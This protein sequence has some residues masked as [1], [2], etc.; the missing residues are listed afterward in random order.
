MA[1]AI[2]LDD[3]AAQWIR[4]VGRLSDGATPEQALSDLN[5][6]GV[7]T[8]ILDVGLRPFLEQTA[9]PDRPGAVV[10]GWQSDNG[11]PDSFLSAPLGCDAVGISRATL[12]PLV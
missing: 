4:L 2:R 3:R 11:D 8:E 9:D 1:A 7:E 5:A 10:L 12:I 6:V